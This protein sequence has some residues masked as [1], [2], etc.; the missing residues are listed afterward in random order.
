MDLEE[1]EKKILTEKI[2]DHEEEAYFFCSTEIA[3]LPAVCL[4]VSC[5]LP[6]MH[7]K[8]LPGKASMKWQASSRPHA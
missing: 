1:E 4:L 5:G 7:R 8:L 6:K 2:F 3:I